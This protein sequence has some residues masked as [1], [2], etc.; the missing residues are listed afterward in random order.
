MLYATSDIHGYPL[1]GFLRLLEKAGFGDA[2]YLFVLGDVIDR[3]G[4]GGAAMLEWLARR[5]NAELILGNHEAMLLSCAFLFEGEDF[6]ERLT[7]R[8]LALFNQWMRNGAGA[9]IAALHSLRRKRPESLRGLLDYLRAAP[10]YESVS[11]DAGEFLLVHAGL[12]GFE[13]DRPLPE[14]PP[15]ALLW[16]RP[17]PEERFFGHIRTILG[18]TPT[19]YYGT[20]RRMFATPTW[21]DI[22]VGGAMGRP[23][24]LLRLDDLTPVYA[25]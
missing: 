15:D 8:E 14:Y 2:D 17:V 11:T 18:H 25:D 3:N 23:P 21:I 20:P 6:P 7:N 9:T 4:D 12:G 13:P 5:P 24:M 1:D 22:D 19:D 10:L 16:H